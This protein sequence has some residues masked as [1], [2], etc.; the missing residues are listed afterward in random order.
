MRTKKVSGKKGSGIKKLFGS[1]SRK[2]G[3]ASE[4]LFK[5]FCTSQGACA[6][7]IHDSVKG[8]GFA[9][10]RQIGDFIVFK[11][12]RLAIVD[13]KSE[14]HVRRSRLRQLNEWEKIYNKSGFDGFCFVFVW[15]DG[16]H[17]LN[18]DSIIR[19]DGALRDKVRKL[20]SINRLF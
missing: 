2:K 19:T 10:S 20:N 11:G 9:G 3:K 15:P 5:N 7:R 17:F 14:R 13:V 18:L 4:L 16:L 12:G 1:R 6:V 8:P